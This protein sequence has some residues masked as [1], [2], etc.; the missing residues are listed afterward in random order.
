MH[1]INEETRQNIVSGHLEYIYDKVLITN[2]YATSASKWFNHLMLSEHKNA[3]EIVRW[4]I[5][6]SSPCPAHPQVWSPNPRIAIQPD[7]QVT[8][9]FQFGASP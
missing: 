5:N 4:A 6:L 9:M 1:E 3:P 7:F 2:P 8:A